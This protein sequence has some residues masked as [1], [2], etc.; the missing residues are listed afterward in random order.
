MSTLISVNNIIIHWQF[1]LG[2]PHP[3]GSFSFSTPQP[4]TESWR[5]YLFSFFKGVNARIQI[6]INIPL[7][8]SLM[9]LL[10]NHRLMSPHC[11][12]MLCVLCFFLPSALQPLDIS[13]LFGKKYLPGDSVTSLLFL[14]VLPPLFMERNRLKTKWIV[15]F[16]MEIRM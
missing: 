1:E 12:I 3:P 13:S 2:T 15:I 8:H 14:H 5:I 7:R 16:R 4:V 9:N 11:L 6:Q 10:L